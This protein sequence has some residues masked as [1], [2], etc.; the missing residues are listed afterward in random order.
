MYIVILIMSLSYSM[1][2]NTVPLL[3]SV[4]VLIPVPVLNSVLI[5][6]PDSV[7]V[8]SQLHYRKNGD[9]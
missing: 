7:P 8:R 1:F 4:S 3:V 5:S 6:V 9:R 2:P